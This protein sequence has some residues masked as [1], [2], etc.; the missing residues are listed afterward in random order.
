MGHFRV[1]ELHVGIR[2]AVN[3]VLLQGTD[4]NSRS[5]GPPNNDGVQIPPLLVFEHG[6]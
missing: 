5:L 4:R 2:E 1:Q 6:S 3:Y